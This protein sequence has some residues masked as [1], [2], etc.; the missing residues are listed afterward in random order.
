MEKLVKKFGAGSSII[1]AEESVNFESHNAQKALTLLIEK[2]IERGRIMARRNAA[3]N[4]SIR[5]KTIT[6][7]GKSI[8]I[9]RPAIPSPASESRIKRPLPERQR[10]KYLRSSGQPQVPLTAAL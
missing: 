9:S 8:S 1:S 3:G 4:G 6:V 10:R 5:K 2:I 7:R